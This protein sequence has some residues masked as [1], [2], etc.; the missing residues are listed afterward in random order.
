MWKLTASVLSVAAVG[1]PVNGAPVATPAPVPPTAASALAPEPP[2][3]ALELRARS[4]IRA[5]CRAAC[6]R[7]APA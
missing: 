2:P 5:A 6:Q 3:V 1:G 4:E 7:E